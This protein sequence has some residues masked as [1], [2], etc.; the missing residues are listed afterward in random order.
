MKNYY[1]IKVK[2]QNAKLKKLAEQRFLAGNKS[3]T[4]QLIF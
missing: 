1:L 3:I 2:E 4:K